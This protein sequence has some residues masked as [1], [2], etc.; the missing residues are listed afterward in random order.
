MENPVDYREVYEAFRD[1]GLVKLFESMSTRFFMGIASTL[2]KPITGEEFFSQIDH[3]DADTVPMSSCTEIRDFAH[4]VVKPE[5]KLRYHVI[6]SDIFVI[7]YIFLY[8]RGLKGTVPT[9]EDV[10]EAAT[11]MRLML[12]AEEIPETH[13]SDDVRVEAVMIIGDGSPNVTD[14]T[15]GPILK[16]ELTHIL[17][18]YLMDIGNPSL[19]ENVFATPSKEELD[20]FIEFL[21]DFIQ[22]DSTI[23][24]KYTVHPI[25]RMAEAMEFIF[26]SGMEEKYSPYMRAI[27]PFF[28]EQ[29]KTTAS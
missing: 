28:D 13:L 6:V 27:A 19:L 10:D 16:H 2:T 8:D 5:D 4:A 17:I 14:D 12:T 11:K 7:H 23:I 24:N 25:T 15:R 22:F 26:K 29:M 1:A 20:E 3:P 9:M 21:C 18:K